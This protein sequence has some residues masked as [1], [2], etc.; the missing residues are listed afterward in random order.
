MDSPARARRGGRPSREA[1]VELED[2][3]LDAATE[4]FLSQG[5]GVTSIEAVALRAR[6]SK[7]TFYHRFDDKAALFG[8]VVHRLI[9]RMRPPND[10]LLFDGGT[11]E[12]VLLRL[13]ALILRAA[14]SPAALALHRVIVAE[15]TRF[16][17][18]AL[19]LNQEGTRQEALN[20]IAALLAHEA[21]DGGLRVPNPLFAAEQFL[22]MVV[23]TPQR[24]ALGLGTP[25]T[26]AELDT[27]ARD[28]VDLL[29]N[30]CRAIPSR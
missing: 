16:P 23:S 8:A 12:E 14:L 5:Y 19:V 18:L 29:L 9:L 24:R 22:Q 17:E 25:M 3:I 20:R 11:I 26:A 4:L 13:A 21:Q 10:A 7:R 15:A 27:W 2:Q 30:G 28:A 1:S 6:I